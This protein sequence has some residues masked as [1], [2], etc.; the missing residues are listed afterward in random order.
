MRQSFDFGSP[1]LS[2]IGV[3]GLQSNQ[4]YSGNDG[5]T[6]TIAVQWDAQWT[7]SFFTSVEY[8]HQQIKDLN[9]G[10]PIT[11]PFVPYLPG[12]ISISDGRLDRLSA[13]ANVA[14]SYGFGISTTVAYAH[15]KNEDASNIGFGEALPYVP[16]R[17]AQLAVTWVNEANV[18][19]TLAANY[20][21]TREGQLGPFTTLKLDDYWTLDANMIWEP[22]DKRF[23]LEAS[24]FNL[25]DEDF[26][27]APGVPGWGRAVK[28][29]LKI[30]F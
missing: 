2:P 26:E 25:L 1:T 15:S 17:S 29:S 12:G 9:L 16:E 11:S 28:G 27:V 24:A 5:Y 7:D 23:A 22:L 10:Y 6:D 30:R 13:T 14:L 20:I 3:L 4:L 8:Q 18:K 19:A 21:G